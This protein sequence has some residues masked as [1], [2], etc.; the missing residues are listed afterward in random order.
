MIFCNELP[1][2]AISGFKECVVAVLQSPVNMQEFVKKLSLY[3]V[4]SLKANTALKFRRSGHQY[5]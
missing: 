3:M 1:H 5:I 4:G 2:R